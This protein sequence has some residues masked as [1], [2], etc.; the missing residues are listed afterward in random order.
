VLN[1]LAGLK[2]TGVHKARFY[3]T[4]KRKLQSQSSMDN[5]KINCKLNIKRQFFI[6]LIKSL[7]I[8]L[9][10]AFPLKYLCKLC[11]APYIVLLVLSGLIAYVSFI[12]YQLLKN[13]NI[14]IS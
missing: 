1:S 5:K 7:S 6:N 9:L 10:F 11:D 12:F 2:G 14:N 13:K 8:C 3:S 4:G